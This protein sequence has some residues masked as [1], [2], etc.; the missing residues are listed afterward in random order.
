MPEQWHSRAR[1][2]AF[3][4]QNKGTPG[5]EQGHSRARAR[6]FQGQSKG[7]PGPEQGHSRARAR[8]FQGQ[9]KGVP[10]AEQGHSRARARSFQGQTKGVPGAE[11]GYS[12]T[13]A[14]A[15]KGL[16]NGKGIQGLVQRLGYPGMQVFQARCCKSGQPCQESPLVSQDWISRLFKKVGVSSN[17]L[18]IPEAYTSQ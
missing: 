12:R 18:Q 2:R 17:I 8:P 10:G 15:F 3:K 4:G 5:P 6:A 13:R 11:Q 16:C 9:S 7:I 14:R 1:A